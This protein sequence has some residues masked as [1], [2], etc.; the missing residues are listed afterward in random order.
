M[1]KFTNKDLRFK[2]GEKATF[3]DGLNANIWWDGTDLRLDSTISGVYPTLSGHLAT[4][5][6]VDEQVDALSSGI[7]LDHG[8]LTG[9]LDDDHPQY[10]PTDASR[11][12]TASVSGVDPSQLYH[13]TTKFYVDDLVSTASGAIVAQI[14]SLTGYATETWVN[15]N[16]V[17]N[18]EMTT[19]SGDIVTQIITDHGDLSGLSDDDHTQYILADGTRAFTGTVSGV[20]PTDDAHLAT[21]YYVD[22]IAQGLDWQESV[23]DIVP[24]ASGVQT[25]G[26]R[27]IA[28]STGG[29][30]TED[31][32]YEWDGSQWVETMPNEGFAAWVEDVDALYVYNNGGWVRF[33]STV[34]HNFLSGLQGGTSDQYYHLT[35]AEESALTGGG[36]ASTYHIHDDRYYTESEVDSISGAIVAQI[37]SLTGYATETWVNNNFIDNSEMTTISGDIVAQIPTDYISEAEMTTISGDIVAQIITDHGD[38]SGLDDDDHTQYILVDGSRGF[39]STVSGVMPSQDYHLATKEYVDQG[40]VDRHGRQAVSNDS[41]VVTV[42]FVDLG[43]TDYTINAILENTTD[44]PPSIYAFIVSA[45]TS[46][47]FTVTLMG[48]TDSANYVLNWTVIED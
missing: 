8:S 25:T 10:V 30:W 9:L 21:K 26:N 34:H 44:S 6:Y 15:T 14:P 27:Y 11:G 4:K 46:S 2:N 5:F 3:G 12:F 23:L 37:P 43:H 36:N 20:D 1:A 48:D 33:G 45:R 35:Q 22:Q 31:Y 7:V 40:G 16:F 47:S 29:G 19:I 32:I 28:D 17:D 13:L 42:N 24:V 41:S 39:T 18:S 38:L